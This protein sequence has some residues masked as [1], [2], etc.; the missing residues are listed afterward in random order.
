MAESSWLPSV[1]IT[2]EKE[3]APS[4]EYRKFTRLPE[5]DVYPAIIIRGQARAWV[6]PFKESFAR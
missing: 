5:C 4:F 6:G 1:E 3:F 2:Q